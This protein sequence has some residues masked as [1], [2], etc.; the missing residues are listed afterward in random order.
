MELIQR[1]RQEVTR[2]LALYVNATII[3]VDNILKGEADA[4]GKS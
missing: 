3:Q 2:I 4:R 1:Q